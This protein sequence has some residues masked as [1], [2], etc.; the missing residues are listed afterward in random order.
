MN[1]FVFLFVFVG[2]LSLFNHFKHQELLNRV[3]YK[4]LTCTYSTC[5]QGFI[6]DFFVEGGEEG[7][8][9]HW[10]VVL[11]QM[12][13]CVV[14]MHSFVIKCIDEKTK[15]L[16]SEK[17]CC[18]SINHD[19]SQFQGEN[20]GLGGGGSPRFPSPCMNPCVYMVNGQEFILS[21]SSKKINQQ[22]L[23]VHVFENFSATCH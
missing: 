23:H 8:H 17:W 14:K 11:P 16:S 12:L 19:M 7:K 22:I 5:V 13:L 2:H 3:L 4:P 15:Q 18:T 6:Q 20:S 21:I 9:E 10:P 1:L